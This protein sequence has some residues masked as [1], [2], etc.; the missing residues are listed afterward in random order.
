MPTR[1]PTRPTRA[2]RTPPG[3]SGASWSQ[4]TQSTATDGNAG[5]CFGCSVAICGD[6]AL[7]GA[8]GFNNFQGS[9]YIF[10][11]SGATWSQQAK[12]VA[13]DGEPSDYFAHAVAISGDTALVGAEG[14]DVDPNPDQGSAYVFVRSEATWSLQAKLLAADGAFSDI[15]GHSV[16]ISGDTALVGAMGHDVAANPDQGSAYLFASLGRRMERA[17]RTHGCRWGS[18]GDS[19]GFSAAQSGDTAL[20][21]ASAQTV[22]GNSYQG[23]AYVFA[24]D[25]TAPTTTAVGLQAY[26]DAGWIDT[27]QT[28]GLSATDAGGSGWPPPVTPSMAATRSPTR[29]RSPSPGGSHRH[30]LVGR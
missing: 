13:P 24:P 6:T 29:R 25:T 30:L 23:S 11:R 4:Q 20:V 27:S 26:G 15:F 21:G 17:N 8:V 22:G 2:P 14:D 9:A 5:E 10:V 3:R 28:V 7:I 16:A 18:G 1:W 19:F 12:L